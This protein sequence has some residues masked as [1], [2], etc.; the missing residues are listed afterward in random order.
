[1]LPSKEFVYLTKTDG[2]LYLK[3]NL[4]KNMKN[5]PEGKLKI[6][7]YDGK[8]LT[9]K[10]IYDRIGWKEKELKYANKKAK[11]SENDLTFFLNNLRMNPTL[12]Y[13]SIIIKEDNNNNKN[14]TSTGRFLE[15]MKKKN[16]LNG[17]KAFQ[18]N[19][20]LYELIR[21]YLSYKSDRIKKQ[22]TLQNS[23]KYLEDFKYFLKSD[24]EEKLSK[25]IIV[26]CKLIKKKEIQHI[27]IQYLYDKDFV[28]YLFDKEYNSIS[29]NIKED[30]FEEFYLIILAI[31]KV[32]NDDNNNE[33]NNNEENQ[34][35]EEEDDK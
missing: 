2:P 26:N 28:K 27:C 33:D 9:R 4:P 19:N 12:F 18:V 17:I 8:L 25:E 31:T 15:N 1:V 21:S 13:E 24:L 7:V 5:K 34:N 29:V 16:E 30:I 6:Y 32:E 10:E 22:L 23:Q 20:S 11:L 14:K 3:L 35:N